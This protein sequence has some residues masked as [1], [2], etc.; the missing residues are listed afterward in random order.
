MCLFFIFGNISLILSSRFFLQ[1]QMFRNTHAQT[2]RSINEFS[3]I[4]LSISCSPTTLCQK[5]GWVHQSLLLH[6]PT[7]ENVVTK[8]NKIGNRIGEDQNRKTSSWGQIL[9]SQEVYTIAHCQ[10][11]W[12]SV[13]IWGRNTRTEY[14]KN[15]QGHDVDL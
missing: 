3:V 7:T 14:M 10:Q 9:H 12:K 8:R 11:L 1:R 15:C 4:I 5:V 13:A 2:H 6:I